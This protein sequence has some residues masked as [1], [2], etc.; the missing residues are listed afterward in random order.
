MKGEYGLVPT[1][2]SNCESKILRLLKVRKIEAEP[3][4]IVV[5]L[6]LLNALFK[7]LLSSL[8]VPFAPAS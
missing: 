7:P 8:A 6:G 2:R 3:P 4:N 5:S 1:A